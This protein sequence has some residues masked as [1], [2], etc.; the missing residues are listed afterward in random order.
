MLSFSLISPLVW[1]QLEK[2]ISPHIQAGTAVCSSRLLLSQSQFSVCSGWLITLISIKEQSFTSK[3]QYVTMQG[4]KASERYSSCN[5][6]CKGSTL[7]ASSLA[8]CPLSHS[9]SFE[10]NEAAQEHTDPVSLSAFPLVALSQIHRWDE[11]AV[12]GP[13][14]PK[15][16]QQASFFE[17]AAWG[18]WKKKSTLFLNKNLKCYSLSE[19]YW[20]S[21]P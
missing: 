16:L 20:R 5:N 2:L 18:G 1:L 4:T 8:R 19:D 9:P 6:K 17:C 14:L 15:A 11:S 10:V 13:Q 7:E 21:T 3:L 12:L